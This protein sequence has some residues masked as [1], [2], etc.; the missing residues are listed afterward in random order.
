MADSRRIDELN[1]AVDAIIAGPRAPRPP[2]DPAIVELAR[3][4]EEL[5]LM[6]AE[7]FRGQLKSELSREEKTMSAAVTPKVVL[8]PGFQTVNVYLVVNDAARLIDFMKQAFG[9]EEK[10]RMPRPDGK[11]MHAEVRIGETMLETADANP[12]H[13]AT[14]TAFHMYVENADAVVARAL[15]AGATS[16]TEMRDDYGEHF[17]SVRDP[18]G[19]EWY[20]ATWTGGKPGQYIPDG[21]QAIMPY[22]HPKGAAE[23]MDFAARAFGA[24]EVARYADESGIVRH[25]KLRIG[26][27]IVELGEAHDQWQPL[28][29][30]LHYYV[31]DCDAA[32]RRAIE[33]GA[34]SIHEPADQPYGERNGGV[35]DPWGNRWFLATFLKDVRS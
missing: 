22:L 33:A 34:K 16:L 6:P 19:N 17:G 3:L 18:V 28:P 2:L 7:S 8:P 32:Y 1:R 9:A 21:L 24:E 25:A 11:L 14:P 30:T 4:A 35:I 31:N 5:W 15:A 10:F 20:I 23:F 12:P 13:P 29:T 27:S 26:D